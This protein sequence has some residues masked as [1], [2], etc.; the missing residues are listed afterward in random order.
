[1]AV[2]RLRFGAVALATIG[3]GGLATTASL[4]RRERRAAAGCIDAGDLRT[5]APLQ[6]E[7]PTTLSVAT[8]RSSGLA[9]LIGAGAGAGFML[10][11]AKALSGAGAG[12]P[13][14]R[15]ALMVF[16][17]LFAVASAN[18]L[19]LSNVAGIKSER[20]CETPQ[21]VQSSRMRRYIATDLSAAVLG[22]SLGLG[23]HALGRVTAR[24]RVSDL[25]LLPGATAG[26]ASLSASARF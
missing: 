20:T 19:V 18:V 14:N 21:C 11:R 9:V 26:G 12:D 16:T 24:R 25:S 1:M 5:G 13:E 15:R 23:G 7:P 3:V 17:S 6:C 4:Q 10:G 8:P 2:N 22:F